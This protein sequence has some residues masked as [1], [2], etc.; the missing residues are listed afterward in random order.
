MILTGIGAENKKAFE[1]LWGMLNYKDSDLCAGA[2]EEDTAAGVAFFS[3]LGD[4]LFLDYIYVAERFRR[5]GI[6]RTLIDET[7]AALHEIPFAAVHVNYP[8]YAEDLHRFI[9]SLGF[10][11][12]RDGTAYRTKISDLLGSKTANKLL[13]GPIRDRVIRVSELTPSEKKILKKSLNGSELDPH[14]IDDTSYSE[15]LSLAALDKTNGL[16]AGLVLCR[17]EPESIVISYLINF[18]DD[19]VILL[20][21]LRELKKTVV[22]EKLTGYDLVFLTMTDDMAELPRKLLGSDKYLQKEG[23]VISG[24]RMLRRDETRD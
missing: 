6:G 18:S 12:F 11:I 15:K 19:P 9:L 2:I 23:A 17:L 8:E 7:L 16:P 21:V 3:E 10:K 14:I 5:R 24:I 4:S 20:D 13:S 1:P 22:T